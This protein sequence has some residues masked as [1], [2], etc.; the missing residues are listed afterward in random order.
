MPRPVKSKKSDRLALGEAIRFHRRRAGVTQR[1]LAALIRAR[2]DSVSRIERGHHQPSI[3][4][5]VAIAAALGVSP[6]T[7]LARGA[8]SLSGEMIALMNE[9]RKLDPAAQAFIVETLR[10]HVEF[11][12]REQRSR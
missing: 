3:E 10:Q 9:L 5:L 11:F 7:L 4:R 8:E 6:E 2:P 1:Q 12:I